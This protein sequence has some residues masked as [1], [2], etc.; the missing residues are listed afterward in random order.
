MMNCIAANP[1]AIGFADSDQANTAASGSGCSINEA[2]APCQGTY[3]PL[4]FNGVVPSST[5]INYGAYERFWSLEHLFELKTLA[6]TD[7]TTHAVVLNLTSYA[8]NAANIPPLRQ[9]Y[10]TSSNAV[11]WHKAGDAIYPYIAGPYSQSNEY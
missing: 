2:A 5:A 6:T 7:P 10:W 9:P 8:A 11:L 3:G 4:S 1:G